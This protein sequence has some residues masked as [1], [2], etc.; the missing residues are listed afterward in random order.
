MV[1]K[2]MFFTD[3]L[4]IREWKES[5]SRLLYEYGSDC[6]VGPPAGWFVHSSQKQSLNIIKY[7]LKTEGQFAITKV[8][9]PNEIIGSISIFPVTYDIEDNKEE[10][11][12]IGYWLG[13]PF[14]GNGYIPEA[15]NEILR[16]LFEDLDKKAVYLRHYSENLK[17]KRVRE[18]CGFTYLFTM[19]NDY[20]PL[21][22]EYKDHVVNRITKDEWIK[23]KKR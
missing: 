6:K 4:F 5:D 3:R 2:Y 11:M 22:K 20:Q 18:K 9:S 15:V 1:T 17:S 19:E 7:V 8:N 10:V 23:H 14:W 13:R 12:E 16:Y 21:I